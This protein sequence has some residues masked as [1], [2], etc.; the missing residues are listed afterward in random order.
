MTVLVE[1]AVESLE[2]ALAAVAGGADRLELCASLDVGGTTPDRA[3]V[4]AVVAQVR[5]PVLAMVRPRGGTFVYTR[6]ELA[7]M[8]DDVAS[9]LAAGASGVVLGVLDAKGL[10]DAASTASLVR[11]ANGAPATFHRAIDDTPDPLAALDAAIGAGVSRVL[12][13][14]G[15]PTALEGADRIAAMVARAGSRATI[16]AGGGVRGHNAAQ[17]L[18]RTGAHALHARCGGDAGRVRAIVQAARGAGQVA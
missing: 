6:D 7:R 16:V 4:E 17:V 11:A 3:L 18:A 8:H 1:A 10:V 15:A 14:G 9:L 5:V 2:D 13:S 12:T